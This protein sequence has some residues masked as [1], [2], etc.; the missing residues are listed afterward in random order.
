[1]K[2]KDIIYPVATSRLTEIISYLDDHMLN[3]GSTEQL[4]E[5]Y[6][7]LERQ[8]EKIKEV[9][10]D[11]LGDPCLKNTLEE[12]ETI[13]F[14]NNSTL[15][16]YNKT[17]FF[18]LLCSFIESD[19]G[20]DLDDDIVFD[21]DKFGISQTVRKTLPQK[22]FGFNNVNNSIVFIDLTSSII[23]SD[24]SNAGLS[25]G[26]IA[27]LLHHM[28][29]ADAINNLSFTQA[30]V[31]CPIDSSSFV[32]ESALKMYAALNGHIIH[33]EIQG[34]NLH[35]SAVQ[36]SRISP[37]DPFSQFEDTLIVLSEFNGA[38][39][40]IRKYLSL[41]H[42]IEGFMFKIP[43]VALASKSNGNIFSLRDFR[44]LSEAVQ[45]KELQALK[46]IFVDQNKGDFWQRN[47]G[48][49]KFSAIISTAARSLSAQPGWVEA[50]CNYFLSRLMVT[51]CNSYSDICRNMNAKIYCELIYKIR[52]AIVHNKETELHLS[53]SNLNKAIAL[54]IEELLIVPLHMLVSDLLTDKSSMV[55]YSGP[56]LQ[57]YEA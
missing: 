21:P 56:S 34:K 40:L 17:K 51:N 25:N 38:T 11:Q 27:L 49:K 53:Y 23:E 45:E 15:E 12:F 5:A 24:L 3:N 42:I 29:R 22:V 13:T 31:L 28:A 52:C 9:Y 43:I 46:D 55:W 39:D 6:D 10:E 50:H 54:L 32:A 7:I 44:R 26:L 57:L 18:L 36:L 4:E 14:F 19:T 16:L 30:H 8:L 2:F 33:K 1:M 35:A 48:G 47:I 20:L 41:Y 37:K